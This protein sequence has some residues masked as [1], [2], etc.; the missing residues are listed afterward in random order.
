MEQSFNRPDD[1]PVN[2]SI[3]LKLCTAKI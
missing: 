1:F 3:A 2:Q